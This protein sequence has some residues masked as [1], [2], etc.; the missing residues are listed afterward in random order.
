MSQTAISA[1]GVITGHVTDVTG[2]ATDVTGTR[3]VTNH[4]DAVDN[5][6]DALMAHLPLIHLIY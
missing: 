6:E 4:P 2:H 5:L 1:R 3:R